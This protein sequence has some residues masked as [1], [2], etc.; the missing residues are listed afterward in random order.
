MLLER[1]DLITRIRCRRVCLRWKEIIDCYDVKLPPVDWQGDFDEELFDSFGGINT[2][3][4]GLSVE[5]IRLVS[6][7]FRDD[8]YCY[9]LIEEVY[10]WQNGHRGGD[11]W[12]ML[13]RI[14]LPSLGSTYFF[15]D[16]NCDSCGF[17]CYSKIEVTLSSNLLPLIQGMPLSL[18]RLIM[19]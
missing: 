7:Y 5:S 15:M 17:H 9:G 1:C 12:Y 16:A 4:L 8:E 14:K 10:F 11:H 6:E 19:I 18:S 13:G 2:S 3:F